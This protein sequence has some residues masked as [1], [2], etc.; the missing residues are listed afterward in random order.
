MILLSVNI[1]IV[2][3]L[4]S[5]ISIASV[6]SSALAIAS[7]SGWLFEHLLSSLNLSCA[8]SSFPTN[9]AACLDLPFRYCV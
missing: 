4:S 3:G 2:C 6:N 1:R 8:L 5:S 9:I 7:C